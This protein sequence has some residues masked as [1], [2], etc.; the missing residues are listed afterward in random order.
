VPA[1]AKAAAK[2]LSEAGWKRL[3]TGGWS[4]PGASEV[5]TI[6]LI[7]PDEDSNPVAWAMAGAVAE[8]WRALGLTVD[9]V[10]LPAAELG[11]R[12]QDGAFAAALLDVAVGLDPDLYPLM[13]S[14]QTISG[15]SNVSGLQDAT[16]DAKLLAA[17]RPGTTRCARRPTP[18]CRAISRRTSSSCRSPGA[19]RQRCFARR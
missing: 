11:A 3:K 13:A 9:V 4:A 8:D 19:T 12:L 10:G 1:D 15:G 17:R 16:L 5:Y 14:T 6:E 18:T 2:G 7:S